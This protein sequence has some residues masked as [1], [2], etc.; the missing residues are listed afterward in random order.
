MKILKK[1]KEWWKTFWYDEYL[2]EV[3]FADE[4]ILDP[5]S[6]LKVVKRVRREWV[7]KKVIKKT[8]NM[9]I[10]KDLNG[11]KLEIQSIEPFSFTITKI[12]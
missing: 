9:I 12:Y 11:N 3:Y 8:H 10:A 7:V 2:L 6:N 4:M 1:F 5:S